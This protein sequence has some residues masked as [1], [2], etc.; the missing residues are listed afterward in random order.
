V[1]EDGMS[2]AALFELRRVSR[3]YRRGDTTVRAVDGIDLT[4]EPGELVALEGPSGSGKS[5]L[6]QLLGTLDRPDEGEILF[7]GRPLHTLG[8]AALAELRLNAFGFVFQQFNLI[9]TLTAVENVEAA[10][11]PHGVRGDA[12]R[13][14][15]HGLLEE[16][17]LAA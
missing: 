10:L 15:A 12:L 14:R 8:D 6:L 7:E 5:T 13:D 4:I 1:A 11:A 17:G 9:P 3:F 2:T 16:V